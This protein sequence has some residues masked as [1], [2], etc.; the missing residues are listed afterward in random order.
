MDP[1]LVALVSG[2]FALAASS[3]FWSFLMVKLNKNNAQTK[4][5][6]ALAQERIVYNG[7]KYIRRGWMTKDE[8]E[9]LHTY[10][11]LPYKNA[12]GNGLAEK[13]MGEVSS[14]P[15]Y[16]SPPTTGPTIVNS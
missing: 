3:G 5:V 7:L 2:A 8:F 15:I 10:L 4:L 12:G 9:T 14:L 1:W 6:L 16:T 13:I 11:Y